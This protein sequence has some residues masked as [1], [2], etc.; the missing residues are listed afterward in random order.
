MSTSV[1]PQHRRMFLEL[2]EEGQEEENGGYCSPCNLWV[3]GGGQRAEVEVEVE[4]GGSDFQ[5]RVH[6]YGHTSTCAHT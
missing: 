1:N 5:S 3:G 6:A 2:P 4:G